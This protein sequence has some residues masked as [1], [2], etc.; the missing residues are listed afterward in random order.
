MSGKRPK[1]MLNSLKLKTRI[2]LGSGLSIGVIALLALAYGMATARM[3]GAVGGMSTAGSLLYHQGMADMMHDA[4]RAD[5]LLAMALRQQQR[6]IDE[7]QREFREHID[8]LRKSLEAVQ[9]E[10][11]DPIVMADLAPASADARAY[12]A[13]AETSMRAAAGGFD[14]RALA[15]LSESFARLEKT[16]G[17][18]GE[19]IAGRIA[20]TKDD[21][22]AALVLVN[23]GFAVILAVGVL[24]TIAALISGLSVSRRLTALERSVRGIADDET[25]LTRRL[26]VGAGS[27]EIGMAATSLNRYLDAMTNIIHG[28]RVS[29]T[30]LRASVGNMA[31]L[32]S[33]TRQK[34]VSAG[35]SV[36]QAVGAVA[37]VAQSASTVAE[38][39]QQTASSTHDANHQ[40]DAGSA[41][42]GTTV[43]AINTLTANLERTANDVSQ[44]SEQ[45]RKMGAVLRVIQDVS[46]QTNLLALN[47]AIEAARAGTHGRGF[48]V[49]ADEVRKL[50]SRAQSATVEIEGMIGS[51]K[52]QIE[53]SASTML[54]GLKEARACR[55]SAEVA[56]DTFRKIAAAVSHVAA[57]NAQVAQGASEQRTSSDHL[58]HSMAQVNDMA[59]NAMD[60][61]EQIMEAAAR[62]NEVA[63]TLETTVLR[64]KTATTGHEEGTMAMF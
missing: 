25:D 15:D 10:A 17:K 16:M 2:L 5:V 32:A 26:D 44:L 6:P 29:S 31:F 56:G 13:Q 58:S 8:T 50:A 40:S 42:V 57:M 39:A 27:D 59:R 53:R 48:A 60:L 22:S 4:I 36:S 64:F 38:S 55:D 43:Q 37:Q 11:S 9:S 18:L 63:E 51:L 41:I 47:A 35:E 62:A 20:Q 49:V 52:E 7:V 24:G 33:E 54:E 61:S 3:S 1:P 23:R 19:T 14:A 46:E 45:S 28:L 34:V 21:A 30:R 12:I